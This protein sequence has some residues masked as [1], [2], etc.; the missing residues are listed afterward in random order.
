MKTQR[1]VPASRPHPLLGGLNAEGFLREYWQK[2]PLLI[3][4]AVP[5]IEGRLDPTGLKR[6]AC[7]EEVESR[8]VRHQRGRWRL[9]HGPFAPETLRALPGRGWSLLVSGVNY[10]LGYADTLLSE[11]DFVP[12]ARLDD[13]MVSLAPPGGGVGPHFDSYDVFLLQG[14]GTRRWEV[15]DQDDLELVKG[16]PL[17]ILKRFRPSQSWVLEP[18]DMLYL[19]PRLAH[20]GVALSECMTWSIG[21]RAPTH[22][23]IAGAFLAYLQDRLAMEGRYADPDLT[24]PVHPAE[25]PETMVKRLGSVID[26]IH[27]DRDDIRDFLGTYLSEPKPNV[28]FDPPRRPMSAETFASSANIAGVRLDARTRLLFS[29]GIFFINGERVEVPGQARHALITLADRRSLPPERISAALLP[30][31][32]DWY[33]AGYLTLD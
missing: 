14:W 5:G 7:R 21:F 27:W 9:E 26:G 11:F 4:A 15:S 20:N 31:L 17:R 10:W 1:N 29:G 23:E 12:H 24:V 3:R 32:Y 28:F 22:Q 19:P 16:A 25:L 8:L 18:G 13:V 6:L 33:V 2:Q 30:L